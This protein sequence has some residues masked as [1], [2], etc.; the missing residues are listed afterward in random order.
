[1]KKTA[2]ALITLAAG[3][4]GTAHANDAGKA[5]YD[6]VCTVCHGPTAQGMAIY[7]K[8]AGQ[9]ADDLAAK[10]HKYKAGEQL[11]PM[12]AVMFPTAQGLSDD[13]IQA[14]TAYIATLE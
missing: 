10:L 5:I 11:G 13:D 9:S 4:T 2:L 1:M 14:V 12:S 6:S 8:L 3:L 7:P